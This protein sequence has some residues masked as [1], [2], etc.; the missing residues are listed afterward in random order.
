MI[1]AAVCFCACAPSAVVDR[2]PPP[3][4]EGEVAAD[5]PDASI[6]LPNGPMQTP[7]KPSGVI[8][9]LGFTDG[10]VCKDDKECHS[11]HCVDGHCCQSACDGLCMSCDQPGKFGHC[12]PV[13]A[14][15]DP[16]DECAEEAPSSCGRDGAC[17]GAGA[18]RRYPSGAVCTAGGC[19]VATERA[20]SLCDGNGTCVPGTIKSCA[21]AICLGDACGPPCA[22]DTD[23][24]AGRWC[25]AG[26]CRTQREQGAACERSA[27]CGSGFCTDGV[28][29]DMACKDAC[30]ACNQTGSL[31]VCKA[32][33]EGQDPDN[34]CRVEAIGTCGNGGGCNGRGACRKHPMGTWCGY[35]MCLNGNQYGDSICDGM[36][37]CM[38]GPGH[39][40]GVYACNGNLV[41]WNACANNAQCAPG[42]T[43]N[44]HT[45]Q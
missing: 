24:P 44:I 31:G 43:C 17:D 12:L 21:P 41:C 14:G 8:D 25:D 40:C 16:D 32:I 1:A 23:C 29:C 33:A 28:C 38:R 45:C 22:V 36:G 39:R 18:C 34:E 2:A 4:P 13:D 26:T 7:G 19:D 5:K 3:P 6:N 42:H 11:G 20:A 9:P 27:Q 37:G 10:F 15:Q 30:Y 35:G